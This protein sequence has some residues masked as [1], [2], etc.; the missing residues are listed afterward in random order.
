[1]SARYRLNVRGAVYVAAGTL[2]GIPEA[3]APSLFGS[4]GEQCF[5]KRQP[6]DASEV[7][8]MLNVLF[9]QELGG[10]PR[11]CRC[12]EVVAGGRAQPGS[13][14]PWRARPSLT[15]ASRAAASDTNF[16]AALPNRTSQ[17]NVGTLGVTT[18]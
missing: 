16:G 7:E 8:Q 15:S 14:P 6:A 18:R 13:T 17:L 10:P 3:E 5:V 11:H 12:P 2:C 4:D 9:R 1:V